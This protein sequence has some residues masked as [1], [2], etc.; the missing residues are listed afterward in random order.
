ME[1]MTPT[2]GRIVHVKRGDKPEPKAAI[3]AKVYAP[4]LIVNVA[5]VLESGD[6]VG[7]TG[8]G[9]ESTRT[10]AEQE[11]WSWPPRDA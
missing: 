2:V 7:R 11:C 8:I 9:H 5:L 1:P 3:I 4:T 6:T 10:S